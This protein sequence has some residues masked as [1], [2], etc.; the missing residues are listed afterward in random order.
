LN[1]PGFDVAYHVEAD[2]I[3][4]FKSRLDKYWMLFTIMTAT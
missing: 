1:G 4:S 2:S 3:N